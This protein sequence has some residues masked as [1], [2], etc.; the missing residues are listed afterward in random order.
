MREERY[1][2][3]DVVTKMIGF[4][5]TAIIF[6]CGIKQF[7]AQQKIISDNELQKNFWTSQNQVYTEICN[8]AGAMAANVSNPEEFTKKKIEFLTHYYGEI[9]LVEDPR[10]DSC[11]KSIHSYLNI[12]D[13]NDANMVIVFKE[14][15]LELSYACKNTSSTFKPTNLK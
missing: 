1:R 10:V 9:V 6:H 5:V 12:I 14:R 4:A 3:W 7:N 11:M 2:A 13:L 15:V 8:N